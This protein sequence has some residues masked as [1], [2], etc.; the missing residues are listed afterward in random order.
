M[1]VPNP[2]QRPPRRRPRAL[3]A[4]G[5]LLLAS[6]LGLAACGESKEEKAHKTVCSARAD[7]NTQVE[8]IRSLTPSVNALTELKNDAT[9]IANDLKKIGEAQKDLSPARKAEV[10]K[11]TSQFEQE[12]GA[13][14][15]A[16]TEGSSPSQLR[17]ALTSAFERLETAYKRAL[18]PIKCS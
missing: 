3:L 12:A 7:I 9:A 18:A 8:H 14:L 11:A 4:V 13:A 5:T 1:S 10:Q 17:A 16:L 15:K 2:A 6:G